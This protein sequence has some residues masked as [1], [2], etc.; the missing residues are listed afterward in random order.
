MA[1]VVRGMDAAAITQRRHMLLRVDLPEGPYAA[2][3]GFGNL[4]P[5]APLALAPRE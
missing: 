5:L 3:V 2:R 4:T 1:R